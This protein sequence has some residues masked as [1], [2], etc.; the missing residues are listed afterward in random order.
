MMASRLLQITLGIDVVMRCGTLISFSRHGPH[1]CTRYLRCG[2]TT[3]LYD[4]DRV[5]GALKVTALFTNAVL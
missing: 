1:A 4:R 3:E 2:L 5:S